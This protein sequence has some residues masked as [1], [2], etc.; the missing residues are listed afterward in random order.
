MDRKEKAFAHIMPQA[1]R[2]SNPYTH[3]GRGWVCPR[4]WLRTLHPARFPLTRGGYIATIRAGG[5]PAL[6]LLGFGYVEMMG[7][8]S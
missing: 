7:D 5:I 4:G 1:I 8:N 6:S 3:I 2:I